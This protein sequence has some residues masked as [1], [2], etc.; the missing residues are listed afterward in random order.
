[1]WDG[2]F[3]AWLG[4]DWRSL[5]D[6]DAWNDKSAMHVAAYELIRARLPGSNDMKKKEKDDGH[7]G[8]ASASTRRSKKRR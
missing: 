5:I 3:I 1:M 6:T 4:L 7:L 2:P 8:D